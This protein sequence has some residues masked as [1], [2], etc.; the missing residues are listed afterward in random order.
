MQVERKA[1]CFLCMLVSVILVMGSCKP[2]IPGK[3]LQ[4]DEMAD[5]LYEYHIAEAVVS[6]AQSNDSLALRAYKAN[7]LRKYD[8]SQSD[9]DSS[10]VYYCRHTKLLEE[11]YE[12]VSDK[13]EQ[14][15]LAQGLEGSGTYDDISSSSDTTNIWNHDRA[16][17]L[18]P[19]AA[20]NSYSFE[21]K[22]DTA[23]HEGDG[24]GLDFDAQFIYQDGMRSAVAVMVVTYEGDSIATATSQIT[25]SSH[26]HLQIGNEGGLKVKSVKGFWLINNEK[27]LTSASTLKLLIVKNVKLIRMHKKKEEP[28]MQNADSANVVG[29][30]ADTAISRPN[31]PAVGNVP[32]IGQ[33]AAAARGS[34]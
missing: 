9:F 3:Y 12:K 34:R 2:S 18:S 15:S 22:A 28:A 4:T 33:P 14:E 7:I 13:I 16:F 32:Q 17:V 19:Y 26:Y 6:I 24:F 8:V 11:V 10:M 25:S 5:I 31:N 27:V 21:M 29:T 1:F 23:F 30:K 20:T